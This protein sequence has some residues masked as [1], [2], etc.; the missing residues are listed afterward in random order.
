MTLKYFSKKTGK[1]FHGFYSEFW[2]DESISKFGEITISEKM[3]IWNGYKTEYTYKDVCRKN[4]YKDE[5][6]VLHFYYNGDRYNLTGD[7]ICPTP[8]EFCD[9]ITTTYGER[10]YYG[11]TLSTVLAKY[12]L[13]CIRVKKKVKACDLFNIGGCIIKLSSESPYDKPESKVWIDYKF[14]NIRNESLYD[15]LSNYKLELTPVSDEDYKIYPAERTY[16]SDL[17]SLFSAC[18]DSYILTPNI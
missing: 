11:D 4:V 2:V 7:C 6:G 18:Q 5:N 12:G 9:N 13:D 15:P 17:V 10:H 8:K 14:S 16:P 3:N 1:E